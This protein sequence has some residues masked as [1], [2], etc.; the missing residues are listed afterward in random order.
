MKRISLPDT[1]FDHT[2]LM[3]YLQK[4]K[5]RIG[6]LCINCGFHSTLFFLGNPQRFAKLSM[7]GNEVDKLFS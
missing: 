4:S 1:E 6:V 3:Q 7:F 5:A 2:Q